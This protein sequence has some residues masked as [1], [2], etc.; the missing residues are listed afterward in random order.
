MGELLSSSNSPEERILV[1]V[2]LRP[3][4]EKELVR[5]DACDLEI[6]DNN[7]IAVK[8]NLSERANVPSSY[9]VGKMIFSHL[10]A[11]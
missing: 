4:N 2:R 6:V 11:L 8:N 10:L 7:T 9:N 5:S 1:S 3:M